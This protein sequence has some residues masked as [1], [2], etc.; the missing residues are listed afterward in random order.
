MRERYILR[1][2][3]RGAMPEAHLRQIHSL[4]GVTVLDKSPRMLLVEAPPDA[5]EQL[6]KALPG[7]TYSSEQTI[8]LPDPRPK[9]RS[10]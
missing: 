3:G 2:T 9:L 7:W 1:F 4:P 8:Q 10:S 6:A 5:V